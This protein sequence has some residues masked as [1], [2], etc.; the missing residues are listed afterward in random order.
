MHVR[1]ERSKRQSR[2]EAGPLLP[3]FDQLGWRL[4]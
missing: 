1:T 2:V 3:L 4:R